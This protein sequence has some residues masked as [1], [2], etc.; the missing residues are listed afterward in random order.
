MAKITKGQNFGGA[1]RYVMQDKKD[2]KLLDSKGVL[3]N[4]KRSIINSFRLQCQPRPNVKFPVG[5]ISLDFSVEDVDRLSDD[6]M[7]KVA[8]EYMQRMNLLNTQYVIVRHHDREHP[9]CH[10]I[11]NRIDN[12]GETYLRQ[13]R[14]HSQ[15][16]DLP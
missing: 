11:F 12:N 13:E 1:V 8:R 4:D 5:H 7:A 6:F 2:A 15:C 10:V 14:P 3:T 9:H 16:Q